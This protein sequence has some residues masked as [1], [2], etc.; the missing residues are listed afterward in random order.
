MGGSC[1][2]EVRVVH[3]I[4]TEGPIGGDVRRNPDGTREFLDNWVDISLT[5]KEL[6]SDTFRLENSDSFG[7]RYKFNWFIMDFMGFK[8]NP[9]NRVQKYND[10]Y[11]NIKSLNIRDD[12]FHWHYHHPPASG[13]GDQWSNDW[14]SSRAWEQI[15]GHRIIH[16]GDFPEAFRAGGT[17]ED[18]KC[19]QWLEDN[20]MIDYSNRSFRG[21]MP[22][23]DIFDFNWHGAPTSWGYYR[24][25]S[26]DITCVGDMRRYIVRCTDL[27]SRLYSLSY[28]DVDEA[29]CYAKYTR[30]PLILSYFSH[31]HRD[32]RD[33][34]R[35]AISLIK[36]ASSRSG[37]PYR[38][39][40]AKRALQASAG[41]SETKLSVFTEAVGS[42]I[43]FRFSGKIFQKEPF[44]Y[45]LDSE[46]EVIRCNTFHVG[47]LCYDVGL[48]R[49]TK[50][51]GVAAT[52][53][54]GDK[55]VSVLDL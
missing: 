29:F 49:D 50:K 8:T 12:S 21:S 55:V 14:D 15:L 52:S 33:E 54:T 42:N 30:R 13:V 19:S 51:V 5:L 7:G 36:R 35:H 11:D 18:I 22:T 3:C 20:I 23:D 9:K 25:H 41:L 53:V 38:W 26:D 44:V 4:D 40:D 27:R 28:D 17:I 34:T 32:M 45:V 6:T 47:G 48:P 10:T 1:C 24:P 2:P 43:R 37:V 39:D 16:R 46:D 31:D